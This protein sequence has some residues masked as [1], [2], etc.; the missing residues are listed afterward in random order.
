MAL[1]THPD[2]RLTDE[3]A[4]T[5]VKIGNAVGRALAQALRYHNLRYFA[6]VEERSRLARE[7]HDSLAQAL[8]YLKLKASVTDELLS[9]GQIDKA[10]QN[11]AEVKEIAGETYSDVRETIFSLRESAMPGLEFVPTLEHYVSEY[12]LHYGLPVTLDVSRNGTQPT[13]PAATGIQLYRIVQEAL[14]N[15]R[16]HA[17]ASQ[18]WVRLAHADDGWRITVEDD[19]RGFDPTQIESNGRQ[20]FGVQIMRERAEG[21]GARL[22]L[23]SQPGLGTR[24]VILV[25]SA[26]GGLVR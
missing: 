7:M 8:A 18:A 4:R 14:T 24:V 11:L 3:G 6:A 21:V 16:T 15:V 26:P 23:D 9:G 1:I 19:G 20:H 22:E 17:G 10:R 25:P 2:Q 13:F 5:L 12:R